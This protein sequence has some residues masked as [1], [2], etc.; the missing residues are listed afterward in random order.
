MTLFKSCFKDKEYL[1]DIADK[2]SELKLSD[3]IGSDLGIIIQTLKLLKYPPGSEKGIDVRC[4]LYGQY[5]DLIRHILYETRILESTFLSVIGEH[6]SIKLNVILIR[7][8]H[9]NGGCHYNAH[10]ALILCLMMGILS[11]IPISKTIHKYDDYFEKKIRIHNGTISNKCKVVKKY[12]SLKSVVR[13]L[14]SLTYE[15]STCDINLIDSV[16]TFV[17]VHTLIHILRT[18]KELDIEISKILFGNELLSDV[19]IHTL[20]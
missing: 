13:E 7:L 17:L 15:D 2:C 8:Y 20:R 9:Y 3:F 5:S 1:S 4:I 19:L 18:N 11:G 14:T 16:M 12:A 6:K 10:N